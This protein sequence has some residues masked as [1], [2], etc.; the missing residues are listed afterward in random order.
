MAGHG[1]LTALAALVCFIWL[2]SPA[3]ALAVD[4]ERECAAKYAPGFAPV[5][6]QVAAPARESPRPAKGQ[7]QVDPDFH[8]C[9]VR[10]TAHDVEPP[11]EFARN[12]YS[13]RQAFNADNSRFI[14][15]ASGGTWHLYDANSLAYIRPLKG[16]AGDAEPQWDPVDPKQ[17]YYVPNNG[18]MQLLRLNVET[19]KSTVAVDF[20][21]KL[22]WPGVAR[23]W[24]QSEGSPSADGRYWCFLAET[25]SFGILG[26]FTYDLRE[27][28]VLGT[29]ALGKSPD[30]A[31]MSPSGRYCVI[32]SDWRSGGT[33]AWNR[34]FTTSRKLHIGTEHSDLAIG[35]NG[36]DIFVFVDF[37]SNEGD[38]VMV[39]VDTGTRTTLLPT[40]IAG[41][42][43]SYHVSGKAFDRPGWILLSTYDHHGGAETW[44]HERILA[45]QLQ[46]KPRI[47]NLAHHHSQ[48]NGYWTE[49]QASVSRDF[50]RVL[51]NSNWGTSSAL[52]VDAYLLRLPGHLLAF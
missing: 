1:S 3:R 32:S 28:K 43:T 47:I 15:Y 9:L 16:L 2:G 24:T 37:Q 44:L 27:Q 11:H 31:S 20:T 14:V 33:V 29:L 18:G 19:S 10:A 51:F 52:D 30:H 50:S 35:A 7:V 39:D 21:G 48:S 42:A 6:G 41:S 40:Y 45:V 26:A 13:R 8:I 38:L 36:H 46:A 5:T 49:P 22:A 34:E 25:S 4:V 17:L 23:V 12:D